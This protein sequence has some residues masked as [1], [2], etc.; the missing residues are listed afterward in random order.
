MP[1]RLERLF[2]IDNP[3]H[4]VQTI[5]KVKKIKAVGQMSSIIKKID[6]TIMPSFFKE[7]QK[8]TSEF[9]GNYPDR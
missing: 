3:I 1:G 5:D 7:K 9:S 4:L 6:F 2:T 8:F